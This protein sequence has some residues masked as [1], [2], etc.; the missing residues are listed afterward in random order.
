MEWKQKNVKPQSLVGSYLTFILQEEG[1]GAHSSSLT[2]RPCM[3]QRVGISLEC[4]RETILRGSSQ[5]RIYTS[6]I[7][8]VSPTEAWRTEG[9]KALL[10]TLIDAPRPS[11]RSCPQEDGHVAPCAGLFT[12]RSFTGTVDAIRSALR[13]NAADE[14]QIISTTR[15][16]YLLL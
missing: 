1:G 12:P 3:N 2:K 13:R 6:H 7:R 9:R 5:K 4:T 11:P 10:F 16:K 15:K 14:R 8:G